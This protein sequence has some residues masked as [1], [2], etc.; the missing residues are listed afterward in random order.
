MGLVWWAESCYGMMFLLGVWALSFLGWAFS[1]EK[2]FVVF[3]ALDF[4]SSCGGFGLV[5]V[6][7][8]F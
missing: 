8:L 4:S 1:F 5:F 7:F 3:K 6:C 2:I